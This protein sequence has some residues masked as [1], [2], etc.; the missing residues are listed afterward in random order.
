MMT[1][2][3]KNLKNPRNEM[4]L[5]RLEPILKDATANRSRAF[6]NMMGPPS[7]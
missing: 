4:N 7:D 5:L 3:A 6:F 1:K 2:H